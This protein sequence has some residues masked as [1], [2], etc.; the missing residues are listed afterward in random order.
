MSAFYVSSMLRIEAEHDSLRVVAFEY[1]HQSSD[2][3]LIGLHLS[4]FLA[5]VLACRQP[6]TQARRRYPLRIRNFRIT[7]M[8]RS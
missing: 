8:D 2:N 4:L 6:E 7:E 5:L 3:N 1:Y